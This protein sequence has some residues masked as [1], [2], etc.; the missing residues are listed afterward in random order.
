MSSVGINGFI[1]TN[2]AFKKSIRLFYTAEYL[3]VT[4]TIRVL[5]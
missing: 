5:R 2:S 4:A 1:M 3:D